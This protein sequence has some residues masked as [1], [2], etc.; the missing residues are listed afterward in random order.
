MFFSPWILWPAC[1]STAITRTS[2]WCSR[3]QRDRPM[4]VPEVPRVTMM[5]VTRP[6]VWAQISGAVVV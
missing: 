3:N 2:G 4:A 6:S 5:S 1:G